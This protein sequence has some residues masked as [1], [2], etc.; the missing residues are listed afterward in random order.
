MSYCDPVDIRDAAQPDTVDEGADGYLDD[1]AERA[2]RI[3]DQE[4]GVSP[5]FFEE[6]ATAGDRVFYGGGTNYLYVGA[7]NDETIASGDVT[8]PDA[9]TVPYFVDRDG[10]LI[11]TSSTG[12]LS[13]RYCYGGW[14]MGVPITVTGTWGYETIP[15]DIKHAVVE[16]AINLLR[17]T[18]PQSVK[19]TNLEGQPLR[20][21]IPPRV[22]MIAKKYSMKSGVL[23]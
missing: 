3:F 6:A 2:S 8:M 1:L 12:V 9:Y 21:K 14:P 7:H 16:L 20:E 19:L 17:E 10:Y 4:C 13:D 23:V 22:A 5:G 18:D 11:I 15:A